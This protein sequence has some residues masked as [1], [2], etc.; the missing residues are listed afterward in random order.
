MSSCVA[1]GRSPLPR[2]RCDDNPEA[3]RFILSGWAG[4]VFAT[5]A[6]LGGNPTAAI[7]VSAPTLALFLMGVFA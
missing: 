3:A 4:T 7:A 1:C 6:L 5:L 2:P